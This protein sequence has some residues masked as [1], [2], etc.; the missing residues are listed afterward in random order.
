LCRILCTDASKCV[1]PEEYRQLAEHCGVKHSIWLIVGVL[2]SYDD[3]ATVRVT[4]DGRD[5]TSKVFG[6]HTLCRLPPTAPEFNPQKM[7]LAPK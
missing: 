5:S 1:D 6:R 2:A 7:P 3:G 4:M